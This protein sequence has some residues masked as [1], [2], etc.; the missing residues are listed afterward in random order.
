ML[1]DE[2]LDI[3]GMVR[4]TRPRNK[5]ECPHHEERTPSLHLYE[6]DFYCYSC[7]ANG[8]AFGLIA[9][10]EGRD[11]ADVL[12]EYGDGNYES[13]RKQA[14]T[15]VERVKETWHSYYEW[16]NVYSRLL[17]Q[18]IADLPRPVQLDKIM[19]AFE[20]IDKVKA[21]LPH[22]SNIEPDELR[23]A[24]HKAT[25]HALY[26]L[27][28]EIELRNEMRVHHTGVSP[29]TDELPQTELQPEVPQ[30]RGSSG[31]SVS[32]GRT[33]RQLG[34]VRVEKAVSLN[35]RDVG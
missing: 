20:E 1:I 9:A 6:D 17:H 28:Q 4:P 18:T 12:K 33:T 19:R 35:E 22:D 27:E 34:S 2:A 21:E 30:T 16:L 24:L 8:D 26:V 23:Q 3:L 7:G 11:V 31:G 13:S 29:V 10:V 15:R 5:I 14:A 25:Q 32:R